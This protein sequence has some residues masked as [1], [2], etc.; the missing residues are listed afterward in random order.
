MWKR[1][2]LVILLLPSVAFSC[3]P[4]GP[5]WPSPYGDVDPD[6]VDPPDPSDAPTGRYRSIDGTGNHK[7]H[8]ELGAANT[9]LRRM[10]PVDYGDMV[11][12][13]AGA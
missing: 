8:F 9:P 3:R 4:A 6:S 13:M 11:A 7:I 5:F 12:S 2:A 10:M 1:W